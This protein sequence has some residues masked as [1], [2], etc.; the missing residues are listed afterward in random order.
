[1]QKLLTN[2]PFPGFWSRADKLA[3]IACSYDLLAFRMDTGERDWVDEEVPSASLV[4]KHTAGD[5]VT[6]VSPPPRTHAPSSTSSW[7]HSRHSSQ[8]V[9]LLS[10]LVPPIA[11]AVEK[12]LRASSRLPSSH[13]R[14]PYS[15]HRTS[16]ERLSCSLSSCLATR[17]LLLP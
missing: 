5:T 15:L 17:L 9:G 1:M 13:S 10:P 7:A 12:T 16:D 14:W 8:R 2:K 6:S 4:S 3:V 11:V